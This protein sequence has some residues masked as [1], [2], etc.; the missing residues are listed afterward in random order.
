MFPRNNKEIVI[1]NV[2]FDLEFQLLLEYLKTCT[3]KF[4]KH[5]RLQLARSCVEGNPEF[6]LDENDQFVLRSGVYFEDEAF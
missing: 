2:D 6:Q 5:Q 3:K 4:S 1:E